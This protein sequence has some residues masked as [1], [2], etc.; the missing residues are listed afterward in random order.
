MQDA[1]ASTDDD[2]RGLFSALV[3]RPKNSDIVA[4]GLNIAMA[5]AR[6]SLKN[7]ILIDTIAGGEGF[8]VERFTP[9]AVATLIALAEEAENAA[10]RIKRESKEAR[11]RFNDSDGTHDYRSRDLRNLRRRR[12]QSE[13][14]A[15]ALR[16]YAVDP[17]RL[18]DLVAASRLA[19]WDELA[20]NIDRT[21]R[22][23]AARPDLEP[24]YDKMR[25]AR[26]Q[27]L[28]LVDLSKLS[29]QQR[30]RRGG[31]VTEAPDASE[32]PSPVGS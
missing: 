19:A 17:D 22:I 29:A 18:S 32:D 20:V 9:D 6:L 2:A 23:E 8:D 28:R 7:R 24:D 14:M 4:E 3:R 26:M 21:L 5:A 16:E 31:A 15:K 12:R 13:K 10:A 27:A 1:S 30:S 11:G 25:G